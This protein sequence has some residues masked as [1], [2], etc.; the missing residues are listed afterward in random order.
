MSPAINPGR[1]AARPGFDSDCRAGA[2]RQLDLW[3]C[4]ADDGGH[5]VDLVFQYH[6]IHGIDR[7]PVLAGDNHRDQQVPTRQV[8]APG[9][10]RHAFIMSKLRIVSSHHTPKLADRSEI[11][12]EC[13]ALIKYGSSVVVLSE[14]L[15]LCGN[16]GDGGFLRGGGYESPGCRWSLGRFRAA[17]RPPMPE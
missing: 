16:G 10:E 8:R 11:S 6:L 12:L 7:N 13:R 17:E 15:E 3:P 1:A 9:P 5:P 2:R 4:A 14:C